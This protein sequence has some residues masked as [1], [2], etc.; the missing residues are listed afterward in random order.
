MEQRQLLGTADHGLGV[1]D[2]EGHRLWLTGVAVASRVH[3]RIGQPLNGLQVR[4]VLP[5]RDRRLRAQVTAQA[6][7]VVSGL[8]AAGD[9]QHPRPQDRASEW[10]S[11]ATPPSRAIASAFIT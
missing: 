6:A 10:A 9:G 8:I 3:Q 11:S 5:A 4:R 7:Q 1:A 2:V